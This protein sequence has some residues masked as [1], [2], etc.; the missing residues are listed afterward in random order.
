MVTYPLSVP[1]KMYRGANPRQIA[2]AARFNEL[3]ARLESYINAQ[4]AE[5]GQAVQ[6][7]IYAAIASALNI[8][9][10]VVREVLY[11]VDGGH[12]GFRLSYQPATR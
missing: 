8:D 10:A 3:A 7:F 4:A 5:S 11:P 1:Q 9:T 2:K 12:N 6:L